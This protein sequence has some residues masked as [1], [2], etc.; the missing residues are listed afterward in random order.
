LQ[1]CPAESYRKPE[2]QS[3]DSDR[4]GNQNK[5]RSYERRNAKIV[6]GNNNVASII[7]L[8]RGQTVGL[9][10]G[11]RDSIVTN[12]YGNLAVG[13]AQGVLTGVALATLRVPSA[14][15]LGLTAAVCSLI[16]IVG[17]ILVGLPAAI[18]LMAAGHLWK[19]IVRPRKRPD[20]LRRNWR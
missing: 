20:K 19:G 1:N 9:L 7:P 16:P 15:L 4:P 6:D 18:Y 13:L 12:L 10:A 17:T 14:L 2:Q 8:S 11:I 5:P 3:P